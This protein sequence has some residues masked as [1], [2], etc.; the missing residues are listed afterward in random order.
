MRVSE[1]RSTGGGDLVRMLFS[2]QRFQ[3]L[4]LFCNT[5]AERTVSAS[6]AFAWSYGIYP[7][8]NAS[9]PWHKPFAHCFDV[10]HERISDLHDFL[11][12][13]FTGGAPLSFYELEDHYRVRGS[14]RP[15]PQWTQASLINASRYLFLQQA[16]DA[17][18]WEHLLGD[19][20]CP[21]DAE[22]IAKPFAADEIRFE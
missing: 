4:A 8:L 10:G 19:R 2:L 11:E 12:Q 6:Y 13:R 9:A 15:G 20:Q 3:L 1:L 14:Q 22:V 17:K 16:F 21:L 18:L 7:L 5:A